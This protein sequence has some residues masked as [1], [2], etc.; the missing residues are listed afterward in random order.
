MNAPKEIGHLVLNVSDVECSTKFY[1]DV[2]GFQVARYRPNGTGAFLTCGVVHH[3]LA[4]F[5]APEGAQPLQKGQIG[6][7]HFAFKIANYSALQEAHSRLTAAGAVIDHI[8]DHGMTRSVYFLDPDGIMM[9]LF[10]DTFDTEA[11]GLAFMQATPGQATPI[12]IHATEP[13]RPAIPTT[14]FTKVGV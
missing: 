14:D 5:K 7:N 1:R 4:L 3:N 13:P 12:D 6:L 2:V 10:C 8:V 11:E 9:E